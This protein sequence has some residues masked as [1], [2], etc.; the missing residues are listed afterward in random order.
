MKKK[1]K[2]RIQK[3]KMLIVDDKAVNRYVL[4]SIF[5]DDYEI[6]ECQDGRAAMEVLGE[7]RGEAAVVL[8]DIVMPVCDGFAVLKY[9]QETA[10]Y[11]VPVILIS[12]N[13][14]DRNIS[15]A[16]SYDVADYIQKPFQ[17]DVVR[18]RVQRVVNLYQMKKENVE[19]GEAE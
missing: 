10:L 9:M 19:Y 18:Q 11:D 5:E 2:M 15:R 12:S 4:K 13:V 7:K 16:S 6:I 3:P 1:D 17:E 8:L 14:D